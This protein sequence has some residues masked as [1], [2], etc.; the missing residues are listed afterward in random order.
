MNVSEKGHD[1]RMRDLNHS[2]QDDDSVSLEQFLDFFCEAKSGHGPNRIQCLTHDT[3]KVLVQTTAG[4]IAV[5][6]YL[7]SAGFKYVCLREIQSNR[8]EGEFSVYR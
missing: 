1:M 2:V 5:C 7:F 8:I 4:L 6:S 3:K